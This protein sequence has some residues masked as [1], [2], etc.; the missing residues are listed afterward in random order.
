MTTSD[1]K[2]EV[3]FINKIGPIEG[4]DRIGVVQVWGYPC[5]VRYEDFYANDLKLWIYLPP[6]SLLPV[7]RK[8]FKFLDQ[9]KPYERIRVR[10]Y[11][12]QRSFGLLV[13]APSG[14][15]EG[16]DYA[17]KWCIK[18][19]QPGSKSPTP[20]KG[21]Y[22]GK[23]INKINRLSRR[24]GEKPP[25][26]IVP[27]RF[28]LESLRRYPNILNSEELVVTTEKLHGTQAAYCW[29]D[30]G[31]WY[32][33][34]WRFTK[35]LEW[36]SQFRYLRV[37]SRN[38]WRAPSG[39]TWADAC[40]EGVVKFLEA[41]K[42]FVVFGEIIGIGIQELDYDEKV[43]KLKV[44]DILSPSGWFSYTSVE[45]L[46]KTYGFETVPVLDIG[47]YDFNKLESF[48]EGPTTLNGGP[49][50]REGVVVKAVDETPHPTFGRKAL[51]L[52]GFGYY[53]KTDQAY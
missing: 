43:P 26:E 36:K 6:D 23:W 21:G 47:Y 37:R 35:K 24:F 45:G 12:G 15:K 50:V 31:W 28:D 4:A 20:P 38:V 41:Y 53:E 48:A 49:H 2:A 51:K 18:H 33:W 42:D 9:G 40:P 34:V 30:R 25:V 39:N 5:V 17:K 19:Y 3:V 44:F 32:P 8:E 7:D 14:A 22:K 10:K 29:E 1:H 52:V 16:D 13:K 11:K 27:P 46:A